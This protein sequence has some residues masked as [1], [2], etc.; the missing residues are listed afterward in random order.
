M[1]TVAQGALRK[2]SWRLVAAVSAAAASVLVLAGCVPL[3][4]F[5]KAIPAAVTAS[6]DRISA[7]VATANDGLSGVRIT[8]QIWVTTTEPGELAEILDTALRTSIAASPSCPVGLSLYIA[9]APMSSAPVIGRR[10]I[11]FTDAAKTLGVYQFYS[12]RHVGAHIDRWEERY[13]P[14]ED[15]RR[16]WQE[17]IS[18]R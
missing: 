5:E 9:E 7:A 16:Q 14:C 15:L 6:D 13:G 2:R 4:A 8:V 1:A 3:S 18:E 12:D 11:D 17:E 10:S